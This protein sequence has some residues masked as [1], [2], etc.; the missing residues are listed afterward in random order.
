MS[1]P[2]GYVIYQGPSEIDESPIVVVAVG[3]NAGSA[4]TKTGS[5]IQ[6]YIL[7]AD[8]SPIDAIRSGDDFS[9]CGDCVHR[10][11]NGTKRTCYVNIGQGVTVV[12]KSW[13]RGIYPIA[14]ATMLTALGINRV[15][16]MGTYGDPAAVPQ[17]VWSAFLADS[18]AHTG[19]SHQW[20]DARFSWLSRYA[21]ASAD[22]SQDAALAQFMGWR[23]FRVALPSHAKRE[24]GER[25][26]PAS[27]EAGKVTT[28]VK[29]TACD[30]RANNKVSSIVIQAHGG[31]AVM[32][33][34][35]RLDAV[36]TIAA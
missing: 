33:N 29:C 9:V 15:I 31:T 8:Q 35:S 24:T 7:R 5:L 3:F 10:G 34:V 17:W 1:K 36:T 23:T 2:N 21:M 6:T 20:R 25:M 19:Y 16:R 4:N 14:N 28:C 32:A 11:E 26:C 30:G 22:S 13:I 18:I 12:Y 27:A